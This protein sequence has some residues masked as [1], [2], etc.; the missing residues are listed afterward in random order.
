MISGAGA[1]VVNGSSTGDY[2]PR[3]LH[4]YT[5][6]TTLNA[7]AFVAVD[8]SSTGTAGNPTAGPV[9]AGTTPLVLNG[10]QLRSGTGG[11]RTIGNTVTLQANT[12]FY[13]AATEKSLVF[14]G[15]VT[16]A[17]GTRTLT[18]AVGTTVAGTTID[19][20]GAIG[21]AGNALGIVKAGAG[22]VT[23]SGANTYTGGTTVNDG[24]LLVTGSLANN[25]AVT[26]APTATTGARLSFINSA[27]N[28]PANISALSLGSATG[29]TT[30]GLDLG[31]AS[32]VLATSA[33]ATA[34][35]SIV[36]NISAA[37]G[38]GA[39]T[40]NLITAAGGL[41]AGGASYS[42][43]TVPGGF[44]YTLLPT[45][46]RVQLSVVAA[47]AGAR[48]WRGN[49]NNSWATVSGATTNWSTDAAGTTPSATTPAAGD[50]VVFS[51]TGATGPAIATTLDNNFTIDNL[52]FVP[53]PTGLTS[54]TINPG[55]TPANAPGVLTIAPA[56]AST[57]I[58]LAQGAGA[59]TIAAPV[60]LGAA[61]TWSVDSSTPGAGT[62]SSLTVSGAVSGT[63]GAG[64]T[65]TT[66]AGA[67]PIVLAAVGST[68]SGGSTISANTIVQGGAANALSPNTAWTV[69][70]TLNTGAFNQSTGS[71][72]GGTGV[73]QNGSATNAT[74]TV[75]GDNAAAATFAGTIQNGST[76]T[77]GITKAGTGLQVLSGTNTY[78]G[79][80]TVTAGTL[81]LGSA[82]AAVPVAV[83]GGTLQAGGNL[84]ATATVT[85]SG[86][87]VF[88]LFGAS[89]TVASLASAATN[90]VTNS[91]SGTAASTATTVGTPSGT[92]VF[93]DAL[94]VT[95]AGPTLATLITDGPTRK[96]Q[97]IT[98]N[99]N[100]GTAFMGFTN[101]ALNTF[102]G[103]LVLAN[104]GSGT[105]LNINAAMTGTPFGAGPIIIGQ[106]ATDRAGIYFN[107]AGNTLSLPVVF[108]TGLGTDRFGLRNDG[109]T[110]TLSGLITAN[111]DAVFSSNSATA[112]NTII[113]NKVTGAGGLAIDLSQTSTANT[114][115][116]VTLNTPA[117]ANDYVGDTV[118]GRT[119]GTIVQNSTATLALGQANQ[120][121]N[122]TNAGNVQVLR[123]VN[124]SFT[125]TGN[126]SLGAFAE[127]INGLSGNGNVSGTSTLTL[128]DN[129]ATAA[130]SGVISG[131]G[132]AITKVGTGT[133][134]FSGANTFTGA[135]TVNG[136][137]VAFAASPATSGPLGN[138]TAVNLNGGGLSYTA[139]GT[140]A[141]NRTVSIGAGNGTL[142]VASAGGTLT[143]A[144]LSSTGGNLVKTGPGVAQLTAVATTLN[145]GNAG[146]VV[147]GGTLQGGFGTAGIGTINV[148]SGGTLSFQNATADVLTL[149]G[150]GG[151][152]LAGG[153]ALTFE[154]G[155]TG[156]NDAVLYKTA[157]GGG[158]VTL[159][160]LGLTGFGAGTYNLLDLNTGVTGQLSGTN[161]VLGSAPLGFNYTITNNGT[162][163]Q[164]TTQAYTPIYW[165]GGQ[166]SSWNTLGAAAA[167]WT[168]DAAGTLDAASKP[169]ATDTVIFSAT[170][171]PTVGNAVTTTL[172]A[173]FTID[174][175]QFS[176]VPSGITSV[177]VAPGAGG[178]LTLKPASASGGLAILAGGGNATI[179][180]PLTLDGTNS[181]AQTWSVADAGSTLTVSGNVTLGANI[182]KTGAGAL[183]L[184]GTNTGPGVVNLNAGTLNLNSTG[185]VGPGGLNIANGTTLNNTSA[186]A[187][188]LSGNGPTNVNG[189]F[190][191]AG[192]NNL[193]LG[194][195][196]VNLAGNPVVTVAAG[197]LTLG[198]VVGGASNLAKA[199]AGTLLLSGANTY[200]GT[201]TISG[202]ILRVSNGSALGTTANG[203]TQ[204]GSSA[205]ELDG[206]G[207]AITVNEPLSINGGGI[208]NAGALRNIAGNNTFGG[209]ITMVAQSRINSDSGTLTLSNAA[210]VTATNLT[211]VVG[212]TGNTTLSGGV[213]L[214]TGGL[215]KDGTGTLTLAGPNT[216]TGNV[217]VNGGTLQVTGGA[218]LG[219]AKLL[220]GYGAGTSGAVVFTSTANI[221]F[222]PGA[223]AD[224]FSLGGTGG[225]GYARNNGGTVTSGQFALGGNSAGTG[226]TG[227]F[228]QT[229]GTYTMGTSGGWI[230]TGW[231][232]TDAN[233]VM[234]IFGGTVNNN[235]TTNPTA[236][237]FA[238]NVNSFG[239]YNVLG[240]T[241]VFNANTPSNAQGFDLAR[242][243][244]NFAGVLN[245][246][247]GGT[248]VTNFVR[249]TA[250]SPSFLGIDNGTLRA[251]SA[252]TTFV[253]GLTS[254]TIYAGGATIDSNGFAVTIPQA[255]V[256]PTGS[257]L[258]SIPLATGGAGYIG[259]PAVR[260]SGGGGTGATAIAIVDLDPLSATYGQVTG[261]TV[262]SPGSGYTSAPTV[263]LIGGGATTAATAAAAITS[264]NVTT[265]GLTKTGLGT[266]TLTGTNTF[267]G[268]VDI[269][270]GVL[271]VTTLANGGVASTL[272]QSS[273]AASNVL[274]NG[275]LLGYS[276]TVAGATDRN[277]TLTTNGGGFDASGSTLGTFTV[278]T[279]IVVTGTTGGQTLTLQ[280]TGTGATGGGF[281]NSV[282]ANGSG[283]NVT[284]LAKL[285]TGSWTLGGSAANTYTGL[286]TV[287]GSN[288]TAGALI[289]AKT[290]GALAVPGN[291][292][293]GN[294][295]AV[296]SHVLLAENEQIAPTATVT[297]TGVN[298]GWSYVQMQGKTQTFGNVVETTP[299]FGVIETRESAGT[300]GTSN[301][302]FNVA[303]GTQ[304]YQGYFRDIGTG[305]DAANSLKLT[306]TGAGTLQWGAATGAGA[307]GTSAAA[308]N[309]SGGTDIQNGTLQLLPANTA[310][311]SI[312]V[313][314]AGNVS[315]NG[316]PTF[317]GTLDL[318]GQN[319]GIT[320][321]DGTTG[322]VLGQVV[323][324]ATGTAA[325][326]SIGNNN[327]PGT[328]AGL[329]RDNT[330]G[331][332]TVGINKVGT[333]TQ[334]LSGASTYTGVTTVSAGTLSV[335]SLANGGSN[336]NV[337]ASTNAAAN[338]VLNG[339]T[340]LYTG[341]ATST[342]RLFS[343]QT[344]STIDASG[345]GPVNFS[346]TGSMGFNGGVA[347]KT[348]TLTG[349]NT[350][351]NTVAAAIGNN[352][353]ATSVAKTGTGTWVLA[354][355]NTY[356]G[357]TTVS[358][359]TLVISGATNT[360]AGN[361][362]VGSGATATL[363]VVAGGSLTT[364][365]TLSLGAGIIGNTFSV[366]S[367]AA[368]SA[369]LINN[370][371]GTSYTIDG[372]LTSAGTWTVSTNRSTDTFTGAG[373]ITAP[374]LTL[375]NASTGVNFTG[376]GTVNIA[377]AV[378]I[379]SSAAGG[380]AFYTQTSGTLNA[381]S[382]LLGDATT[383]T[384]TFNLA[385]GR[386][387]VGSGGIAATG[388]GASTR[389]INLGAGTLGA[390]ASW[391]SAM[392][393]ALTTATTTTFNTLDAADN[394]TGRTITLNGVLSGG[395]SLN[396]TGAGTLVLAAANTYTGTTTVTGGI[397]QVMNATGSATGPGNV[398]VT[399]AGRLSGNGSIAGAV[400]VAGSGVIA[401]GAGVGKL[402]L[403]T[404]TMAAGTALE[405][406]V[407]RNNVS[408]AP[409]A[410]TD[411]DQLVLGSGAL[412]V[413]PA[414]V[415]RVIDLP[416]LQ[417]GDQFLIVANAGA[418]PMTST[419]VDGNNAANPLSE[420]SSV[421][422]SGGA[423]YT[424]S[425]VAGDG[426]DVVLTTV[427]PEP[428]SIGLA[429]AAAVGLLARRRRRTG[430][431]G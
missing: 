156:T 17:G 50:T 247:N 152:T 339:G 198:G 246:N 138:S 37:A 120:I 270:G 323:N 286:T 107:T 137:L 181:S 189:D 337:G 340:L 173:A 174:S 58:A 265:G 294:G 405:V 85:L 142:N 249:A 293:I 99:G 76:G 44:T 333:G 42:L 330:T 70:G 255:L 430:R 134:T 236:H 291:L 240:P 168:T 391:S 325:V 158:S 219:A 289:L 186:A 267:A 397:L 15:P 365:G 154:L 66:T 259:A 159:N 314:G 119:N 256:G 203:T 243:T 197:T 427:V 223:S 376:T 248:V 414:T 136:G 301:A 145:G 347:A 96:T 167:N 334:V 411:Y 13:T 322:A 212:G 194:T 263:S 331:T 8:A 126:L 372:T 232:G 202:G 431:A 83:S 335:S 254:A 368:V 313:V 9:G 281:L 35:N 7:G 387:N 26:V 214:G 72:V 374:A 61:Q 196:A 318:N 129:N 23:F 206:S 226:T 81:R 357:T 45:D 417:V 30:L 393:M 231:V 398:S 290:G 317:A 86:T 97:V 370:P 6:G 364:T 104:N 41:T 80:T 284:S 149:G 46:T 282:I 344:S 157:S 67:A 27:A 185:A 190:T 180:A 215:N 25:A 94:T 324:N 252:N 59:V 47:V 2:V 135:V 242:T 390:S 176:A 348:L 395:G 217:N 356:T 160:F 292:T 162:L 298:G 165:R 363:N 148:G 410:G 425:Y 237:G 424:I 235:S 192:S 34:T 305:L 401:P 147:N 399:S 95:A 51:A 429:G 116:T 306:K 285:G 341:A 100:S 273:S 343:L 385:G 5:G 11:V 125:Q 24:T 169:G 271:S 316:G 403:A 74:L 423:I 153:S 262:T 349:S 144:S 188:T 91:G 329:I 60:V 268:A 345:T 183:T 312:S 300:F 131:S 396:K 20:Q 239:M 251:N 280:G 332:G 373:T 375:S 16:I 269:R 419:F 89:Q 310:G 101:G 210:A 366:A 354:G 238:T 141:L 209:P 355:T 93:V 55:L 124:G 233:G 48:Y 234:N 22:N 92:G 130:F 295:A 73:V 84:P 179:S 128:G 244:G 380:N 326:L 177:T 49:L 207:G 88:D 413:D 3:T 360:G 108:N 112:S 56:S 164:L 105:R 98:N 166:D 288:A 304:T 362:T 384:R 328:F 43:G 418:T 272:G 216:S 352:T 78:T 377:G 204:S 353:A 241:A 201:T 19:F 309:Y 208:S 218:T 350:G 123:T 143:V 150:A 184:S 342:D 28:T 90:T 65:F 155:A 303:S 127:T 36:F 275:G 18:S 53:A 199:G 102:S 224:F 1:V 32:D 371:W 31:T 264:P 351:S 40:Y 379:A 297:F 115:H 359:G 404:A 279:N 327:N 386:V 113:T 62:A 229:G 220:V 277:F 394:T 63:A 392:A 106:T 320:G 132:L 10:A 296:Q 369:G 250:A 382:V 82:V 261:F 170:G 408:V 146:V 133:Q 274:L 191:F 213:A 200:S 308:R 260:I 276:G 221:S 79:T 266:L 211:L 187:V 420:G 110:V 422:G 122:G 54:V 228:E 172:D 195:G 346:N 109:V 319:A 163:V 421:F 103:G 193:N 140:N 52:Q 400:N 361:V 381:G 230:L 71:L 311:N 222:S 287:A 139:S 205:L 338:L 358:A 75:G 258:S 14:T 257:G 39:G 407:G 175:L 29:A 227:V 383:G 182:N 307:A 299:G 409:V 245:I 64:V 87:G 415:L 278:T 406:E 114:V 77:L 68:Y 412:G 178:S 336:S 253:S 151:L 12:T 367:G 21:D 402:T 426:N 33:A 38:F 315:L 69:N 121:P 302:I 388:A 118:V 389:T 321:L 225:Y 171:T 161:F 111:S 283:T 57:G 117:N 4:T 416:N 428:S 378:T